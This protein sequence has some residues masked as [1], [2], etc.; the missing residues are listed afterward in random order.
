MKKLKSK[1]SNFCYFKDM[2]A[3]QRGDLLNEFEKDIS[4]C[5]NKTETNNIC[6][7]YKTRIRSSYKQDTFKTY[8]FALIAAIICCSIIAPL[9]FVSGSVLWYGI[10]TFANYALYAVLFISIIVGF[11]KRKIKIKDYKYHCVAFAAQ[12]AITFSGILL[13]LYKLAEG[14][15]QF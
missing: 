5:S 7:Q 10:F 4:L 2:T 12:I 15:S 3:D 11:A 13:I 9:L 14:L 1:L 6:G 8:L